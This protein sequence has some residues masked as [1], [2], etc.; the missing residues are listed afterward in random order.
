MD[1]KN[2][3]YVL[4]QLPYA[5]NALAPVMSEEQVRLHH[6]KHHAAYVNGANAVL[7]S[8]DKARSDGLELDYGATAKQL[9]FNTAGHTL[10]SLFWK[11]LRPSQE[12]N[13]PSGEINT[14]LSREYSSFTRFKKEFSQAALKTEGS[15]GRLLH[16]VG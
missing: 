13:M 3:F 12:E 7:E 4:P 2:K 14:A 11:N 6:D 9:A 15:G 1:A 8:I 5:Y 16:T 10:H